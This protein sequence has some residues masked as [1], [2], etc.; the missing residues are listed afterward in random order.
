MSG[1]IRKAG[2]YYTRRKQKEKKMQAIYKSNAINAGIYLQPTIKAKRTTAI[3]RHTESLTLFYTK[4]EASHTQT[5]TNKNPGRETK[6]EGDFPEFC[7]LPR[8]LAA[9]VPSAHTDPQP[10]ASTPT[11]CRTNWVLQHEP[12]ASNQPPPP[13]KR[14]DPRRKMTK[15]ERQET[16]TTLP[17]LTLS[18]ADKR[19]TLPKLT[20]SEA[21]QRPTLPRLTLSEADQ[22]P[23][24][25]KLTSLRSSVSLSPP[26]FSHTSAFQKR[27][28]SALRPTLLSRSFATPCAV[29]T[30]LPSNTPRTT[31]SS[32][33]FP[34]APFVH[35]SNHSVEQ[36][37]STRSLRSFSHTD[38]RPHAPFRSLFLTPSALLT[39]Q[40]L[41]SL[42][43]QPS[44][45]LPS[46]A[47]SSISSHTQ[48]PGCWGPVGGATFSHWL[49]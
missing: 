30:T 23:T 3:Y 24:L 34:H 38:P 8:V 48:C 17:K 19:P 45:F 20:L 31:P 18:E 13:T 49:V 35:S 43:S 15:D 21:D 33:R 16:P 1:H 39:L 4:D 32:N 12:P 28:S 44:P 42:R 47:S 36:P 22:R 7:G 41:R 40:P 6:K 29:P 14:P 37:V 27:V 5:R 9:R 11:R 46:A 26:A 2:F 25:P 10:K